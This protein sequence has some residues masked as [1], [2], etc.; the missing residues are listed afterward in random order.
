[1]TEVIISAVSPLS[2][3][4]TGTSLV[5]TVGAAFAHVCERGGRHD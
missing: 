4:L 3:I 1:M 2:I 5:F